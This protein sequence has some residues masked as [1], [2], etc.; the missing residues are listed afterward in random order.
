MSKDGRNLKSFKDL[1]AWMKR[2]GSFTLVEILVAVSLFSVVIT[3]GVGSFIRA[4]QI[5]RQ[6]S[7]LIASENNVTLAMEQMA[8]EMRTGYQFCVDAQG[9][10]LTDSRVS[11]SQSQITFVN[12]QY[13]TV[14]YRLENGAIKRGV[15]V[16]GGGLLGKIT[17]DNVTVNYL[18]FVAFGYHKDDGW[19]P[20]ITISIGV[21][22]KDPHFSGTVVPLQT[23]ISSR[24]PSN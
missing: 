18:T 21:S 6:I 23:T 7:A 16:E 22:P 10:D 1:S 14:T 12:A 15:G 19:D 20:R 11:C 17:G 3:L 24:T 4:L 2:R 9:N 5:Q 13:E 8:R